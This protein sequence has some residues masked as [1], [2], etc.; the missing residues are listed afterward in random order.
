MSAMEMVLQQVSK[1]LKTMAYPLAEIF[2]QLS[3][4]ASPESRGRQCTLTPT[5]GF[6]SPVSHQR[7]RGHQKSQSKWRRAA[8]SKVMLAATP[9]EIQVKF[10]GNPWQFAFFLTNVSIYMKEYGSCFPTKYKKVS[11]VG[12][13]LWGTAVEWF[14]QLHDAMALELNGLRDFMRALREQFEDPLDKLRA[15]AASQQL[16]ATPKSYQH[17]LAFVFAVKE[18]NENLK[19]L[20]NITLGFHI[21]D[22]YLSARMTQQNT[23]QLLSTRE[24]IV[25]NFHC[26]QHKKLMAVIGSLD[27]EISL[28][29]AIL[30]HIYKI[31]QM[32][33]NEEYQYLGLVQLLHHFQW[34]WI[35]IVTA[36]DDKGE[37]FVQRL[38]PLLYGQDI[39]T[40]S[41]IKTPNLS[42]VLETFQSLEPLLNMTFSLT[43]SNIQVF[44]VNAD[45]QT[46]TCLKWLLYYGKLVGMTEASISKMW[47]MTAN[48]DF[49]SQTVQKDL[50]I[51]VFH[52]MLSFTIH[53]NELLGFQHFL[54][55]LHLNSL[56]GDGFIRIFW[57]EAFG[58]L[59]S[60]SNELGSTDICTGHE[61]LENLP[62][63][64][65]ETTMTGQSYSIYNAVHAIAHALHKML[66]LKSA[67][68]LIKGRSRL[69]HQD[70]HPWKLH[71]FLRGISFNNTAGD[72]VSFDENGELAGGF[73]IINWVTF[74]N[75]SFLRRKVGMIEPK[76][77]PGQEF[78]INREA[79]TWHGIF[80]Q[81]LPEARCNDNCHPGY[82]RKKKEGKPFCCYDCVPCPE[83]KVAPQ[84]DMDSCNTCQEDHYPNKEQSQC[85]PKGFSFLSYEEPLG[86][87][88]AI[89]A[90]FW[91]FITVWI[92]WIFIKYHNTPMIRANNRSLT[93]TL[94]V[95]LLL[96][97]LTSLLFIG[98]PQN[99]TCL[100]RQ[101]AFGIIFSVAVS[102]VL[103]KNITVIVAFLA[104]Q[105]GSQ[106]RKW[107]GKKLANAIILFCSSIQAGLCLLWLATS[108]PFPDLDM[109]SMGE[110]IVLECNEGS[111]VMFY[112]VL[113][114]MGFL[115]L[116]SFLVAFFARKL[117]DSF[118]EAKFITFSMLAFCSVWLS[119]IPTYLSTKGKYMVVVEIFSILAS[120]TGLLACIFFPKCYIILLRPELNKRDEIIKRKR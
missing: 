106:M 63:V 110:E 105:P 84:T 51:H 95:F 74:P 15:K 99:L 3:R 88:L 85:I 96:C 109:H 113:G 100:F 114:Y 104:T 98:R 9:K 60:T 111:A 46:V 102:C 116:V 33:P 78:T 112:C 72:L 57:E 26:D 28:Q 42:D 94:L 53:T 91:F 30:L 48:W 36:N 2:I 108:P 58:C 71:F 97:F 55:N 35:G 62:G 65:F 13:R 6:K 8:S 89:S 56:N 107:M 41:I 7:S 117:P 39:C 21:F 81:V 10:N 14:M 93:Y 25:P 118:N 17:I 50:D 82:S 24:R 54:Q 5:W 76:A 67:P 120:S 70:V 44:V 119:F 86:M 20:P 69:D 40:A 90:C 38:V 22:S 47:I 4:V 79:I 101:M 27:S 12:A 68:K 87:G 103:A 43:N 61:K 16:R 59:F 83:G 49:S 52:G 64:L 73:D 115:A 11:Q 34:T 66:S 75:K 31:P 29:M 77:L 92:L 1:T 18:I 32:V 19:I 80:N 37:N 23:L 45:S